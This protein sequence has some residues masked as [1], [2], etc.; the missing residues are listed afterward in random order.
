MEALRRSAGGADP[1]K[2]SKASKTSK[3]PRKAASGQKEM[4][5]TIAGKKPAKEAAA[6]RRPGSSASQPRA[7]KHRSEATSALLPHNG[8]KSDIAVCLKRAAKSGHQVPQR[9]Q[10]SEGLGR[11]EPYA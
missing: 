6:K 2:T 5:M 3:K 10:R 9:V 1:A 8:L 7:R 11:S 4:L